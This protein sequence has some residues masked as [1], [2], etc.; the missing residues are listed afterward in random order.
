MLNNYSSLPYSSVKIYEKSSQQDISQTSPPCIL[1]KSLI[2]FN[3]AW[4]GGGGGG[5]FGIMTVFVGTL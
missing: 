4:G 5:G 2:F 3:G 1:D